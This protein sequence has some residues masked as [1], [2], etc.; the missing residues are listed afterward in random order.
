MNDP[1]HATVSRQLAETLGDLA[2]QMQ[3]LKNSQ[4][5]LSA[6]VDA[7]VPS[8]PGANWA[9][10]SLVQR[11]R[12]APAVATDDLVARLDEL[13]TSLHEGPALTMLEDRRTLRVDNLAAAEL[14]PHFVPSAV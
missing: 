12:V 10:I 11:R 1:I 5:V 14:W 9:G 6:I 8:V 7:A 4:R 13:Q 2:V 3:S